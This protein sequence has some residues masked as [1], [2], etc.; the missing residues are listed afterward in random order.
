MALR[1]VHKDRDGRQVV[2]DRKLTA[3]E[4]RADVTEN[5]WEQSLQ[6]YSLR[7]LYL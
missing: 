1:P 2:A 7:V 6:P 4:D 5:W 3:G